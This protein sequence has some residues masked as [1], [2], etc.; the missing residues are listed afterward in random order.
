MPQETQFDEQVATINAELERPYSQ[1][2][3]T[4]QFENEFRA[5]T[6][7]DRLRVIRGWFWVAIA[8]N[9]AT[10]ALDPIADVFLYG[11]IARLGFVVPVYLVALALLDRGPKWLRAAAAT[12]PS[13]VFVAA[14]GFLAEVAP[15]EHSDRYIMMAGVVILFVNITT[16]MHFRDA[17]AMTLAS[18]GTLIAWSLIYSSVT[19]EHLPLM[20]F[21][22]VA[23]V[24]SLVIRYR[25]EWVARVMFL[26]G[27]RDDLKSARLIAMTKALGKLA[28]TDPMTGLFN[29]RHLVQT[30]QEKWQEAREHNDWLGI[31][32][33][34][35]DKFKDFNDTAGHD[36]GDR[37]LIAIAGEL[38]RQVSHAKQYLARYGGEEFM[39]VVS[40]LEPEPLMAEAETLRRSIEQMNLPH[41]GL[42][43]GAHVTVSIGAASMIPTPHGSVDDLMIAAD[44]AL[45]AAKSAGR[46]R[47]EARSAIISPATA[48]VGGSRPVIERSR[49]GRPQTEKRR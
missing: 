30:L 46:N 8:V 20:T 25:T 40:H 33:I 29:R 45:Y 17:L 1:L 48:P 38:E 13:V 27:L 19:I 16:P 24:V 15:A 36:E 10:L 32:M 47:V 42:G 9:V 43:P 18:I 14:S 39:A 4:P 2:G 7:P 35:I 12:V 44:K 3:L 34:D 21:T 11:L 49:T 23:G 41:P 31:L 37:C 5:K 28:E 6:A 22:A 26:H